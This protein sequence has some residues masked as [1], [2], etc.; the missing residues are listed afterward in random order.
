MVAIA[1]PYLVRKLVVI[2]SRR[3]VTDAPMR[4]INGQSTRPTALLAGRERRRT[5][6]GR[7]FLSALRIDQ[8]GWGTMRM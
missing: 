6:A 1:R 5:N 7:S 3:A 4:M 2:G 8:F